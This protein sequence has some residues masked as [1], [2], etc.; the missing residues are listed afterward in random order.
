[1]RSDVRSKTL[2]NGMAA[3]VVALLIALPGASQRAAAQA[4]ENVIHTFS[5]PDGINPILGVTF[6][7][8]RNLYGVAS[9]GGSSNNG[10]VYE[11]IPGSNGTWTEKTLLSFDGGPGGSTPVGGVVLDS[12]GNLY[13]TTKLGGHNGVGVVYE[14]TPS[15]SGKWTEIVLH[16]FGSSADG[17]YP[18]GNI[19]IDSKGN[20]FGTTE[21]GG[22]FGNGTE[23]Q[24]GTL[25]ELSLNAGIWKEKVLHSFG[26][27]SDGDVPKGGVILDTHGNAYGTTYAGG[28]DGQG[29][30]F[31]IP[32][33]GGSLKIIHS[34]N[35]GALKG[36]AAHPATGVTL[37][38]QGNLYGSSTRGVDF[39]SAIGSGGG[40]V[41]KLSPQTG[42]TWKETSLFS[43][44]HDEFTEPIYSNLALDSAG[45][46][47]GIAMNFGGGQLFKTTPV[48]GAQV[49]W[50]FIITFGGTAG[51]RPAVGSLA[52]DS[53][54]NLYGA[55][56][57][58]GANNDGVVFEIKR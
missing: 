33:A 50:N 48:T 14:V 52:I 7:S 44:G 40:I 38:S 28:A 35:P 24:G 55:T 18:V 13:G 31:E 39:H 56:Q 27:G 16:N 21:G 49:N 30:V 12:K 9:G 22:A 4:T 8:A 45:H 25:F 1:M 3:M 19:A 41:Y 36:D 6:D 53:A 37:D 34:F 26:G 47:Y 2:R 32:T 51:A 20:I 42:G 57:A 29:T 17:A 23:V 58:G 54:G 46:L 5:G 15:N 43:L 11:L 10:T